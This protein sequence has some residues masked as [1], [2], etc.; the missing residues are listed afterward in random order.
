MLTCQWFQPCSRPLGNRK[1]LL[2]N[3]HQ[4]YKKQEIK[5][6]EIIHKSSHKKYPHNESFSEIAVTRLSL[7][8]TSFLYKK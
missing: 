6:I 4:A 8:L 7:T 3:A 5:L 2:G 1:W